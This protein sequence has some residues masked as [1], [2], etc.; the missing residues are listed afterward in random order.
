MCRS[1]LVSKSVIS[2]VEGPVWQNL[3]I[4]SPPI[5]TEEMKNTA[6]KQQISCTCGLANPYL[7]VWLTSQGFVSLFTD[8]PAPW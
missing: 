7:C 6:E 1:L 4:K 8:L 5:R 2:H 3:Q